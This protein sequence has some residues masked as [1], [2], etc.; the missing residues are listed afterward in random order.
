MS[1]YKKYIIS[2]LAC[3]LIFMLSL[4]L[5]RIFPFGTELLGK[6]DAFVQFKPM[7]YNFVMKIKTGTLLNYSFNNGLG[8]ATIF[9]FWYYLASPLNL[10][11][12]LFK[13]PNGMYLGA[14]LLKIIVA[15]ITTT[16]YASKKTKNE[17]IIF[18]STISYVFS[19][20][21]LAYYY[22]LPW[23]DIFMIFPVFNYGLELLLDEHK[24]Y[25]YIF[26]LAYMLATNMYL[27]FSVCIYTIL[28]FVI[29]V[30]I[31][32]KYSLK[33][34]LITFD[35]ILLATIGSFLLS[36]FYLYVAY[37]IIIKTKLFFDS[38]ARTPYILQFKDFIKSL[39][40]GNVTLTI[41]E[42]NTIPN[43]GCSLLILFSFFYSLCNKEI[44]RRDKLFILIVTTLSILVMFIPQLDFMMNA[45]HNIRGLTYRY[46]FIIE[47]L[48]IKLFI[49]T[50]NKVGFKDKKSIISSVIIVI[51]LYII[52]FSNISNYIRIFNI[53]F[54][55]CYM[56]LFIFYD[57]ICYKK[58]FVVI[59]FLLEIISSTYL[60]I[61]SGLKDKEA[62]PNFNKN[63]VKYRLANLGMDIEYTNS[64]MYYNGKVTYLMTSVTYNRTI[65]LLR[66]MGCDTY[67]N[68]F[69][70][71][72]EDNYL[73]NLLFNVKGDYYLEKIYAVNKDVVNNS[74]DEGNIK[75]NMENIIYKMT[76]I[77]KIYDKEELKGIIRD[78]K[79][80]FK[81]NKR[82]YLIE[83]ANE[84]GG[85]N[86]ISQNYS[87]F[88][89]DMKYGK[90]TATIYTINNQKLK[91]IYNCLKRNQIKYIYYDDNH[92]KGNIN[93]DKNQIIFTSI[94]Y[95]KD[96]EIKIDGKI[97][98]PI[99]ILDS[100]IGIEVKPGKHL[101]EM[102]Y[103]THYLIPALISISTFVVLLGGIIKKRIKR[104]V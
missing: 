89:Q 24:Y 77:D 90:M 92:I 41:K 104:V 73:T 18:I 37:D 71:C 30:I 38:G 103:K 75:Y 65:N 52:S 101:I 83:V 7:L 59:L 9:D 17:L 80:Y 21:L 33:E 68:T 43:I 74:L 31:Y 69:A 98:K 34:K 63:N 6:S 99:E 70:S 76:G 36:F 35:Y 14:T 78:D 12:L 57:K 1:K 96:W 51:I 87:S 95:D 97:V 102:K 85:I 82:Y 66:N 55:L 27:C 58:L 88:Y 44:K 100:L 2:I 48:F 19:G 49:Y 25:I 20:W 45:F 56:V 93:V 32:K 39:Y 86:I 22:Y 13:S 26:S 53:T 47:F 72:Y 46:G 64:N 16:F 4:Y 54:F 67:E 62:I 50:S 10:I 28:Y 40:Y 11:A 29:Y 84:N 81:T 42:I 91:D 94:P 60:N 61:G 5:N 8:N 23:L 15:S 3:I 79:Y